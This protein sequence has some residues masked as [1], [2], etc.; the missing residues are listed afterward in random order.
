MHGNTGEPTV[1]TRN[2][3]NTRASLPQSPVTELGTHILPIRYEKDVSYVV[4][5]PRETEGKEK[6]EGSL[7]MPI[8]PYESREIS[9]MKADE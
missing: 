6:D 8:V 4:S 9:P 5:E 7:S 3:G 1:S 2:K